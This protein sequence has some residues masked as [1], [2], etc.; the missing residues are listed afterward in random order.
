MIASAAGSLSLVSPAWPSEYRCDIPRA[1]L[2]EG[3][4]SHIA[5]ALQSGGNCRVSFTPANVSL[6]TPSHGPEQLEFQVES[7]PQPAY[8][9][10]AARRQQGTRFAKSLSARRCFVFNASEYCE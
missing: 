6:Q 7:A 3:C 10:P 1:L 4:A 2:C 5:I 9:R 8:R